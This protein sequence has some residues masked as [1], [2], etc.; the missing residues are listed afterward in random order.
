MVI[1]HILYQTPKIVRYYLIRYNLL[2]E[3]MSC[4]YVDREESLTSDLVLDIMEEVSD[5]TATVV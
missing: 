1:I 3:G 2:L 5:L 4:K